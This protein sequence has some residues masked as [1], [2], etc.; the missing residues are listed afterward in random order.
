MIEW[1]DIKG[2]E[3][4]Y[5]ISNEGQ[6]KSL[7]RNVNKCRGAFHLSERTLKPMTNSVG[8]LQ[9]CLCKN[10]K[11][12][13]HR[14]HRLVAET[15]IPNPLNLPVVN[16]IDKNKE[17]NYAENLEWCDQ[18]YNVQ[19]NTNKVEEEKPVYQ[20]TQ[21]GEL[22]RVYP[23]IRYCLYSGFT[24]SKIYYCCIGKLKSYMGFKWTHT[25][26]KR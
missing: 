26:L 6:V 15:F 5:Q 21:K 18:L 7:E 13:W 17:N 23:Y 22:V 25:P 9:V 1:R 19:Y 16:H 4:L 14:I 3:G 11:G 24:P 10:G 12:K 8:Y 20:Y 2:Y